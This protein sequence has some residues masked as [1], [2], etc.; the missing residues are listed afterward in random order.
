MDRD[1]KGAAAE[2]RSFGRRRG[3]KPSERQQRLLIET[4]PELA[5]DLQSPAP[6]PLSALFPVPVGE[7]WLEIGFGGGEHLLW[8]AE[9]HREVGLIGCEPFLDGVVK[10]LSRVAKDKMA[11]IRLH[12]EDARPLLRWLPDGSIRRCFILFPD[13]WPKAKHRKRRLIGR[14]LVEALARVLAPGAELRIATDID[15]YARAIV[16]AVVCQGGFSW[17]A[18]RPQ[19]WRVRGDDW[20]PTRYEQKALREGRRPIFLRFRRTEK[21][22]QCVVQASQRRPG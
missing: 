11:T 15:D 9:H 13:P 22:A 12:A 16:V 6:E 21:A 20:P 2:L 3:R 5:L 1:D 17:L 4:L 10:V 8:Q 14:A 18:E 7:V 19:D